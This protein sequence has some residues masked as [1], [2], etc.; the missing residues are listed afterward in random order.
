MVNGPDLCDYLMSWD[1]GAE[2][3]SLRNANSP[4]FAPV[5]THGLRRFC[6]DR[7]K[8]ACCVNSTVKPLLTV[9][10]AVTDTGLADY[11][12][13]DAPHFHSTPTVQTD[14]LGCGGLWQIW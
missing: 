6:K 5:Y 1:R 7:S 13:R 12:L 4:D 9:F 10:D 2:H 8:L 3:I 14:H 11:P